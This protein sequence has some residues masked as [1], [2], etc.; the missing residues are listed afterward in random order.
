[1]T[2]KYQRAPGRGGPDLSRAERS[3]DE[4]A[5]E[6]AAASAQDLGHAETD[7][8]AGDPAESEGAAEEK[9]TQA[10]TVAPTS[11]TKAVST[12]TARVK[13]RRERRV[14]VRVR[15]RRSLTLYIGS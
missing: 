2:E 8:D 5:D 13:P 10:S 12:S 1:M 4:A 14:S 9:V 3:G 6:R 11:A 15:M 7:H